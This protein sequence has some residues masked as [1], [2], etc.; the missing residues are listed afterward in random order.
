MAHFIRVGITKQS[1][2]LIALVLFVSTLSA[3]LAEAGYIGID[4]GDAVLAHAFFPPPNGLTAAGDMHF[5][6]AFTWVDEA[7]DTN[8]DSD[9]DFETVALH[10]LGHALGLGHSNQVGS[11]MNPFYG[12]GQRTLGADDIDCIR[13][14]YGGGGGACDGGNAVGTWGDPATLT[15][16]VMPENSVV[17]DGN[18]LAFD[19]ADLFAGDEV[20]HVNAAFNTW[21]AATVSGLTNGG[22]VADDG[23]DFNTA[24]TFGDIR[25]ASV[26]FGIPEPTTF[27]LTG[28]GLIFGLARRRRR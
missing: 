5:S 7:A 10:E 23:S 26:V 22:L 20:A 19:F 8:A 9:F 3:K 16:S 4:R 11:I 15:F 2:A 17:E 27:L 18:G 21:I 28:M 13:S 24:G 25:L 14:I 6:R 1:V 12:G